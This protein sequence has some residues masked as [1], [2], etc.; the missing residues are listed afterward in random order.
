MVER[1]LW[2]KILPLLKNVQTLEI[3]HYNSIIQ[4]SSAL[5]FRRG[6]IGSDFLLEVADQTSRWQHTLHS[7]PQ[8]CKHF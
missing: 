1:S 4:S 5:F 6:D 7:Y 3:T 2:K 8:N